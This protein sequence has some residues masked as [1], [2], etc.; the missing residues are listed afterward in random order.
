MKS[1]VSLTLI[2]SLAGSALPVA[3]QHRIAST[4]RPIAA[5]IT[6]LAVRLAADPQSDTADP[7][8]WRVRTIVPGDEIIVTLKGAP[9]AKRYFVEADGS[10]LTILNLTDPALASAAT[11]RLR[12]VASNHPAY[13]TAKQ[14]AFV[15]VDTEIRVG[16]DGGVCSGSQDR[17]SRTD[18][19]ENCARPCRRDQQSSQNSRVSGIGRYRGRSRFFG[20]VP[21]V[22]RSGRDSWRPLAK[23]CN[24]VASGRSRTSRVPRVPP[25]GGG[26]HL[27]RTIGAPATGDGAASVLHSTGRSAGTHRV[28]TQMLAGKPVIRVEVTLAIL[29]GERAR[30]EAQA[31]PDFAAGF[32]RGRTGV[33][34]TTATRK[35]ESTRGSDARDADGS[36]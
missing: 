5:A 4:G 12:N 22:A 18:R 19:R 2:V 8:W 7:N 1:A 9:P 21:G 23:D 16:P 27:S 26:R 33:R 3:A 10:N 6:R 28:D 24:P 15:D 34:M 30:G 36:N 29:L 31:S 11:R 17:R 32:H 25:Q 20:G 14:I 35:E 13:F